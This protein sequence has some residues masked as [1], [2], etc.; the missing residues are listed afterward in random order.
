MVE[1]SP[2]ILT[3][4]PECRASVSELIDLAE[5]NPHGRRQLDPCLQ[6]FFRLLSR[7][8]AGR[9]ALIARPVAKI[10]KDPPNHADP[11]GLGC[12]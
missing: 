4:R 12:E 3:D 11:A 2:L 8:N 7:E 10:A 6:A 5:R 1:H 9:E